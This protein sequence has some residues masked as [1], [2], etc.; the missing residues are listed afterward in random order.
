MDGYVAGALERIDDTNLYNTYGVMAAVN[1]ELD[2][3][4]N[5]Q[6]LKSGGKMLKALKDLVGSTVG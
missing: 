4:K 3:H 5:W 6:R 2:D 1:L